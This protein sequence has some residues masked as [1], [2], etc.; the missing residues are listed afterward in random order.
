MA[1]GLGATGAGCSCCVL[2][3]VPAGTLPVEPVEPWESWCLKACRAQQTADTGTHMPHS[4]TQGAK[5]SRCAGGKAATA[6][7]FMQRSD[8]VLKPSPIH[9]A[10]YSPQHPGSPATAQLAAIRQAALVGDQ[11]WLLAWWAACRQ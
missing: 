10:Y 2:L 3:A 1:A 4:D 5:L 8:C 11:P 9:T 7:R 6:T